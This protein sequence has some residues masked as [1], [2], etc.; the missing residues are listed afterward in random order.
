MTQVTVELPD[1]MVL[2][3]NGQIGTLTVDWSRVPTHVV[4]HIAN[5][6][7]P[8]YLTDAA[9]AGGRDET[10]AQRMDRAVKKLEAMY[11]GEIR[12]RG[13]SSEPVDP[14]ERLAWRI[15]KSQLET[16][17]KKLPQWNATKAEKGDA[18]ILAT[19]NMWRAAN[20][21]SEMDELGDFVQAVL[22]NPKRGPDIIKE[23]QRQLRENAKLAAAA[24]ELISD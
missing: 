15:A 10:N 22:D 24:E 17:A 13:A 21:K 11:A 7:F 9:N 20:G 5:V 2:G 8:Q 19:L 1:R 3:R 23:A 4:Q 6:Y 18:R 12:V 14:V 16:T